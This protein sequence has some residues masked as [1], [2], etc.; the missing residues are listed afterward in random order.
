MVGVPGPGE[1]CKWWGPGEN[2]GNGGGSGGPGRGLQGIG[3][4]QA[5]W[6]PAFLVREAAGQ[7]CEPRARSLGTGGGLSLLLRA[8]ALCPPPPRPREAAG[9]PPSPGPPYQVS[10]PGQ[11]Q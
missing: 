1:H 4:G 11:K 6:D 7:P 2:V 10:R 3:R 9:G 5:G 8:A